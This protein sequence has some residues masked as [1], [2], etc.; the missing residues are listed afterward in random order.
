MK[1]SEFR[2]ALGQALGHD[3]VERMIEARISL[4]AITTAA[5]VSL[6]CEGP[7]A[8]AS[9]IGERIREQLRNIEQRGFFV[10]TPE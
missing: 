8:C 9:S 1:T 4:H 10:F 2:H 7:D 3:T 5:A 6:F